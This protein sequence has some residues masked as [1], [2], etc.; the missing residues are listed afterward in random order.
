[1]KA[2][3]ASARSERDDF[4]E[5]LDR[6]SAFILA[7]LLWIVVSI[8]LITLPAATAGLFRV[9]SCWARGKPPDLFYEFFSAMRQHWL[10]ATLIGLIDILVGGLL[11]INLKIFSL[12]DM[13]N[14]VAFLSRSITL[15]AV[16]VLA[17]FNLYAW[18]LLVTLDMPLRRI[19]QNALRLALAHPLKSFLT[20]VAALVP[21]GASLLLPAI[22]WLMFTFSAFAFITNWGI[23][24]II[25]SYLPDEER[26]KLEAA[27]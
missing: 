11:V 5:H 20:L 26:Q 13:A 24:R 8:P 27:P 14:P 6:W 3:P 23:W 4:F 16:L 18:P 17:F 25:R 2:K 1:M 9:M 7:N 21:V 10:T 19:V 22:V 12:M 15:F